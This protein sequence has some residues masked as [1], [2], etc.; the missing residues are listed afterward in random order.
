MIKSIIKEIILGNNSHV[1]IHNLYNFNLKKEKE[2]VF[3][4]S[5]Y[6]LILVT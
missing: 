5:Y 1:E 2:T 3:Q 4:L 6:I